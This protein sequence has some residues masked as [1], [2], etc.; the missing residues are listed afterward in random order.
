MKEII[1]TTKFEPNF[2]PYL[3]IGNKFSDKPG[4]LKSRLVIDTSFEDRSF[5]VARSRQGRCSSKG[6]TFSE[7]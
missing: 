4:H 1:K 2:L 5:E 6:R 7:N 3:G